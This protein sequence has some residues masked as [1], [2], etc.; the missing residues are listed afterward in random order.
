MKFTIEIAK[1]AT[2]TTTN[3]DKLPKVRADQ[4]K[5]MMF[6]KAKQMRVDGVTLKLA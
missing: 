6:M 3:L 4:F 5:L 1:N 2:F